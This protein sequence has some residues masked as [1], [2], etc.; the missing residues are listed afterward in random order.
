MPPRPHVRQGAITGGLG[1][2]LRGS[3]ID[4]RSGIILHSKFESVG[5]EHSPRP[6]EQEEAN[7]PGE[8]SIL[9]CRGCA[10]LGGR[11][12]LRYAHFPVFSTWTPLT[13]VSRCLSVFL[14]VCMDPRL[15]D[16]DDH[17]QQIAC[18]CA[19]S[20]ASP[21]PPLPLWIWPLLESGSY[22]WIPDRTAL[23]ANSHVRLAPSPT[24]RD[25]RRRGA[26]VCYR[27]LSPGWDLRRNL[28][29]SSL[30]R[31]GRACPGRASFLV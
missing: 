21:L 23:P 20:L 8:D 11:Y 2:P 5:S 19:N 30:I 12:C 25:S 4:A 14:P 31:P 29:Q 18:R 3:T 10:E 6:A 24:L 26:P 16:N 7:G 27:F 15:L 9:A 28:R 22:H 1:V 13:P 17:P